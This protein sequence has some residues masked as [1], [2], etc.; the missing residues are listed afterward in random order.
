MTT[1]QLIA[2]Q[3][4]TTS[5]NADT[6]AAGQSPTLPADAQ[7]KSPFATLIGPAVSEATPAGTNQPG[8]VV[9]P[10]ESETN[11]GQIVAR[12]VHAQ[13]AAAGLPVPLSETQ[14]IP[15]IVTDP[16]VPEEEPLITIRPPEPG[17][18]DRV[19]ILPV[20]TPEQPKTATP[21]LA[22]A[23]ATAAT[24]D[25]PAEPPSD[26]R[27]TDV[28]PAEPVRKNAGRRPVTEESAEPVRAPRRGIELVGMDTAKQVIQMKRQPKVEIRAESAEKNLPS[29]SFV[30]A[31]TA[32]RAEPFVP[33]RPVTVESSERAR[34]S[35]DG[36]ELRLPAMTEL[37][38][39]HI[40]SM[41]PIELTENARAPLASKLA[42]SVLDHVLAFRRFGARDVD[43]SLRP[44]NDTQIALHMSLRNGQVEVVA[45]L[46]RGQF[47][48]VQRHW[49]ELQQSLSQQGIRVGQLTPASDSNA[50]HGESA[51]AFQ[52]G[53]D[54]ASSQREFDQRADA[55]DERPMAGAMTH[56][57]TRADRS[58]GRQTDAP[59][60]WEMWA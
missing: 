30:S 52:R 31:T 48:Q 59:R 9:P 40:R 25:Q 2:P 16:G 10:D 15:M 44:D 38:P 27:R 51:G 39:G 12:S 50:A 26:T 46:E 8:I 37:R 6:A 23:T 45:R 22:S 36:A 14:P 49:G 18:N 33:A 32:G 24:D 43:V 3:P 28:V 57:S 60:G 19:T 34:Q 41:E 11:P 56:G 20:D 47:D 29:R 1:A 35:A 21:I 55:L 53:F 54:H 4:A 17:A 5:V 58:A 13:L 42:V 7:P